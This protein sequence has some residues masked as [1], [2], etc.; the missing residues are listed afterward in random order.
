[1]IFFCLNGKEKLKVLNIYISAQSKEGEQ[2][3]CSGEP[4]DIRTGRQAH[5]KLTRAI[6]KIVC[7]SSVKALIHGS[8]GWK[9]P[10]CSSGILLNSGWASL[11][12][13]YVWTLNKDSVR[14]YVQQELNHKQADNTEQFIAALTQQK[15]QFHTSISIYHHSLTFAREI[16]IAFD[17]SWSICSVERFRFLLISPVVASSS[18]STESKEKHKMSWWKK[19]I[20]SAPPSRGNY[21]LSQKINKARLDGALTNLIWWEVSLPIAVRL[22]QD[23]L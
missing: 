22:E 20:I 9:I 7:A 17:A 1:M 21:I 14:E 10:T 11:Y 16:S 12:Y 3:R 5:T 19:K 2:R 23:A 13:L 15:W 6:N 18:T 4:V 8:S